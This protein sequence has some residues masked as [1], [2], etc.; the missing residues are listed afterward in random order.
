MSWDHTDLTA[1]LS[2]LERALDQARSF[3]NQKEGLDQLFG[4]S[5]HALAIRK[6][7][8]AS[9]WGGLRALLEREDGTSLGKINE[10]GM[11]WQELLTVELLDAV[12]G[13][14]KP[15]SQPKLKEG[16][17]QAHARGMLPTEEPVFK[18]LDKFIDPPEYL[19][20]L[21]YP[22]DDVYPDPET[23]QVK[24]T[25][26]VR[27]AKS[28]RW[29][30]NSVALREGA[31]G[32]RITGVEGPE[33]TLWKLVGRDCDQKVWCEATNKWGTV[34]S[35]VVHLRLP[36]EE[37]KPGVVYDNDVSLSYAQQEALKEKHKKEM[38]K[39]LIRLPSGKE[40]PFN[41]QMS[42]SI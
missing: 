22:G 33:L 41:K 42:G 12:G 25:I 34:K 5:G 17:A 14:G 36:E 23:G 27:G 6:C 40:I 24:L 37:R 8:V 35:K 7:L 10:A 11:A 9:D 19:I 31:D 26:K 20:N 13:R 32:G 39:S 16:L 18:A 1:N 15:P 28:Y 3:P 21:E 29:L 30:K 4:E 2:R 38:Q